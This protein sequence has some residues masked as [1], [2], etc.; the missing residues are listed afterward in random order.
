MTASRP[1]IVVVGD[2]MTDVVVRPLGGAVAVRSDNPA[3]IVLGQG[4]AG[5]NV[6]AWLAH[7]GVSV[8]LVARVGDDAAGRA[9]LREVERAGVRARAHLDPVTRTGTV[10]A[11]V[12][13]TGER[14]MLTDRGA[15]RDLTPADLPDEWFRAP[16]HL[17]LSGYVLLD[18]RSRRVG[19]AAMRLAATAGMAVSVDPASWAPLEAMG[20]ASFLELTAPAHLCLPNSDEARVLT[21]REDPVAAARDLAAHYGGAV[22]K[23]GAHG[24]VW[25][26][27]DHVHHEPADSVAVVDTTGAG[28]AFAAGYLAG[29]LD[30]LAPAEAL[31]AAVHTAATV[32][33][34][35]GARPP[36]DAGLTPPR[37]PPR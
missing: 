2:L 30:G 17:H 27:G 31:R 14:T 13:A 28:D 15:N 1:A 20:A 6:A 12:D 29:V 5:G 9:A 4:G 33:G 7:L 36:D 8:G 32:V 26:D 11:L 37:R 35:M 19:A 3:R 18:E 23:C 34:V 16:A 10:V 25:S 21:G 24:A 22:V